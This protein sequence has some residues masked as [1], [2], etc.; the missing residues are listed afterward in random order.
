MFCNDWCN[1]FN[2]IKF[3]IKIFFLGD[4]VGR[5]GRKAVFEALPFLKKEYSPDFIVANGENLAHGIGATRKT[6]REVLDAGI[7]FLTSGNHIWRQNEAEEILEDKSLPIIRPANYP[8]GTPGD[9]YRIVEVDDRRVLVANVLGQVNFEENCDSPFRAMD[10][11]LKE[12][13]KEKL[14]A[15]IIDSHM[16]ITSESAALGF[17]LDG[18]VSAV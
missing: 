5:A 14:D 8:E 11:I 10:K 13:A 18:R 12:T 15:I 16:E 3:L 17:Y 2:L 7:D 1:L 9:G 6:V 4:I